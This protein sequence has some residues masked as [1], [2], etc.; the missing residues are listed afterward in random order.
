MANISNVIEE[1]LLSVL[2]EEDRLNISRNELAAYFSCAPSQINYV[3]STRFTPERGYTVESRRGGGGFV[4]V[5]KLSA[6]PLKQYEEFFSRPLSEGLSYSKAVQIIQRMESDGYLTPREAN[7]LKSS[8][9]DKTLVTPTAYGKD[10][11]RLSI[12]RA[13]YLELM[14]N[15]A[16]SPAHNAQ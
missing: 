14:K 8:V 9:S 12:L 2:G 16:A 4:T 3:L 5:F 13:A 7:L 11:L 1:F 6:N 10:A 15:N